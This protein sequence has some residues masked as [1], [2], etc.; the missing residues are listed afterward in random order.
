MTT[1]SAAS[2]SSLLNHDTVSSMFHAHTP[3][4]AFSSIS[5]GNTVNSGCDPHSRRDT[6]LHF[7]SHAPSAKDTGSHTFASALQAGSFSLVWGDHGALNA[8][9]RNVIPIALKGRNEQMTFGG[10]V[11]GG[12]ML[13]VPMLLNVPP[14]AYRHSDVDKIAAQGAQQMIFHQHSQGHI[15]TRPFQPHLAKQ[16]DAV[17]SLQEVLRSRTQ[18]VASAAGAV[19]NMPV[20]PAR[21]ILAP[22]ITAQ[23]KAACHSS[24]IAHTH[25]ADSSSPELHEDFLPP[26]QIGDLD[27]KVVEWARQNT[28]T[29]FAGKGSDRCAGQSS[30]NAC[31]PVELVFPRRGRKTGVAGEKGRGHEPILITMEVMMGLFHL[32]LVQA[33]KHLG[34]SPTAIK[35]VCRRLGIKKWPFRAL[36]AKSTRRNRKRTSSQAASAGEVEEEIHEEE[37]HLGRS[38]AY[39]ASGLSGLSLLSKAAAEVRA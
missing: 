29:S 38:D 14:F 6:S 19:Q 7:S 8:S 4:S 18:S 22:H 39:V 26:K 32:P 13:S 31:C 5:F 11:Q 30:T 3:C 9:Q 37:E 20:C 1:A 28:G 35:S 12:N 10:T 2:V 16:Q 21:S 36:S 15:M 23:Y 25:E 17:A 33:S 24:A 34:L 27:L